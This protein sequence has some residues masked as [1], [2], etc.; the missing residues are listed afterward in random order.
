MDDLWRQS[1]TKQGEAPEAWL[2]LI[3]VIWGGPSRS[4][5]T[6]LTPSRTHVILFVTTKY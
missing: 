2:C 5:Q 6:N 3:K 4:E 1:A